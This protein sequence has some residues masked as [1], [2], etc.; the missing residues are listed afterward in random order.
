M[1]GNKNKLL[2]RVN[3]KRRPR[4]KS[5]HRP[6][7]RKLCD[8]S[9]RMGK[10][11]GNERCECEANPEHRLTKQRGYFVTSKKAFRLFKHGKSGGDGRRETP[12]I[13]VGV[14]SPLYAHDDGASQTGQ[15][16]ERTKAPRRRQMRMIDKSNWRKKFDEGVRKFVYEQ[17]THGGEEKAVDLTHNIMLGGPAAGWAKVN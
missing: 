15:H 4:A 17:H 10:D 9:D 7:R 3:R 12:S 6:I 11:D 8:G 16:G 2:Q 5:W 13:Q 1:S 14:V